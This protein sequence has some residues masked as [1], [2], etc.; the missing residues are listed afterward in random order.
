MRGLGKLLANPHL[1]GASVYF[2]IQVFQSGVS[3]FLIPF[4]TRY[5][6]PA[7]YGIVA[8][9]AALS[10]AVSVIAFLCIQE[11]AYFTLIRKD[12]DAHARVATILVFE[13]A[14]T[15]I[16]VPLVLVGGWLM[17][18]T[19]L[20]G[21]AV[22]PYLAVVAAG[23]TANTILTTYLLT[24]QATERITQCAIVSFAVFVSLTSLQLFFLIVPKLAALSYVYAQAITYSLG[25]LVAFVAMARTYGLRFSRSQLRRALVF[26][27]PLV[28]HNTAH[29]ARSNADRVILSTLTSTA[30][31]GLYGLAATYASVMSMA[32][33]AF[34]LVNNPRFFRLIPEP[35]K[36]A[37]RITAVLPVSMAGLSSIAIVVSVAAKDI[38]RLMLA[39]SYWDAY[40]FVPL[41]TVSI[42]TFGVY[43]NVVNVI[44]HS[45]R[46]GLVSIATMVGSAIGVCAS[47]LLVS[48]FGMWGSAAGVIAMNL[49]ITSLVLVFAQRQTR[50]PWPLL[51]TL[52]YMVAPLGCYLGGMLGRWPLLVRLA[53]AFGAVGLLA[54]IA[55]PYLRRLTSSQESAGEPASPAQPVQS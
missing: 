15:T 12:E 30:Q 31:T 50:L 13:L 44:F 25:A 9:C 36:N 24:L 5:L 27:T 3:L 48:R 35:Q 14:V 41:I 2:L 16:I 4:Y 17:K 1:Q 18:G 47:W 29:W 33:D 51:P 53:V 6:P 54:M 46:T 39:P 52:I 38:F 7:E 43:I 34:R 49:A 37:R 26:S 19:T 23:A 20:A 42:L 10:A 28:P 22:F 8:T 45:G 40:R 32:L 21:V 11:S 55:L